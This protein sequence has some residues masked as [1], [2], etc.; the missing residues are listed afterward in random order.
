MNAAA[1]ARLDDTL[2]EGDTARM[3]I[4]CSQQREVS[5]PPER[6]FAACLD[7]EHFADWFAGYGPIVAIAH[8]ASDGPPRVGGYR[9]VHN[10]DGSALRETITEL[11]PPQRHRYTLEGFRWPFS[12]LVSS[13]D[14]LWTISPSPAGTR[15]HWRYR[16]TLTS[17][18][19]WPLAKP[20]LA[21]FMTGAMRRCLENMARSL[22][23][24]HS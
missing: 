18:V 24:E 12:W 8:V 5:C 22:A 1:A 4:E 19:A 2:A 9:V 6:A 11:L 20:L 10:A 7:S 14:A 3:W 17:A 15:I 13:G 23:P 16:F 21:L